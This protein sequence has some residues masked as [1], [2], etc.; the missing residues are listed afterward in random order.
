MQIRWFP[1]WCPQSYLMWNQVVLPHWGCL[2]KAASAVFTGRAKLSAPDSAFVLMDWW[3]K[4]LEEKGNPKMEGNKI[5]QDKFTIKIYRLRSLNTWSSTD[6]TVFGGYRTFEVGGTVCSGQ[7]K[8]AGTDQ[9]S[10][11]AGL[12]V[13]IC[14]CV[15]SLA[16]SSTAIP[17]PPQL[18]RHELK[19]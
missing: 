6:G 4:D 2:L 11:K 3:P 9:L 12:G 10:L 1:S 13:P 14:T 19:L 8:L 18:T 16:L 7:V 5:P 15:T 17:F